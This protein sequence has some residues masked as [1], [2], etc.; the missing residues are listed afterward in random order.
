MA[1][2]TPAERLQPCLLDRL[3][4]DQPAKREESRSQRVISHQRYRQGV[5]RDLEWLFNTSGFSRLATPGAVRI[6]DYPEAFK[7][8]INYGTRQLS[9]ETTP[10]LVQIRREL[11]EVIA[12]FEPRISARSLTIKANAER[13]YLYLDVEGELWADPIP[14][15]LHLKTVLD[16]ESGL[17]QLG[18]SVNG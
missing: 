16:V 9:G 15:H 8:V 13:N 17:C 2:P 10:D 11:A 14:E 4:D 7:S 18:D 12:V 1:D 3:T 5:L 6:E